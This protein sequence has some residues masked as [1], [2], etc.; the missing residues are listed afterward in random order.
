[1]T[2]F[3]ILVNATYINKLESVFPKVHMVP[4]RSEW[5]CRF[6]GSSVL[7]ITRNN[8]RATV[9]FGD[10]S[11]D[12]NEIL[13][14]PSGIQRDDIQTFLQQIGKGFN[15]GWLLGKSIFQ[16]LFFCFKKNNYLEVARLLQGFGQSHYLIGMRRIHRQPNL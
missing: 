11:C 4:L 6:I 16:Q 3:L 7:A 13:T 9:D 2:I 5:S 12:S 14:T 10:G 8:A 15:K 1:M